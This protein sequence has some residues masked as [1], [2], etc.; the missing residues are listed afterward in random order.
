MAD[1]DKTEKPTGKRKTEA[2]KKGQIA[3]STE[4]NGALV[5]V[6]VLVSIS[7]QG[8]AVVNSMAGSMRALFGMVARPNEVS[9]AA[10]LHGILGLMVHTLETT[11]M[12][13]AIICMAGAL[14]ANIAQVGLRPTPYLL[15]P[16]FKK[17]NPMQGAKQIFGKRIGFELAKVLAKVAIVGGAAA[18]SLVP[19][20]THLGASTGTTPMALG[21]LLNSGAHAIVERIVIVYLLIAV[22]DLI[23]QRRTHAKGL[24]MTKQEVKDE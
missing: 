24:K 19:L 23:H 11:A 17:L 2:R 15:K 7:M 21:S 20:I 18:V 14:L 8:P 3:K 16:N 1:H 4:I 9:S 6:A 22:I 12:P 5:L 10:G 13:I